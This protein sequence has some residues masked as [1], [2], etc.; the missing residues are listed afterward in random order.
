[1]AKELYLSVDIISLSQRE[2][3]F[4]NQARRSSAELKSNL[5]DGILHPCKK[6]LNIVRTD[7]NCTVTVFGKKYPYLQPFVNLCNIIYSAVLATELSLMLFS[8]TTV[9]EGKK[10]TDAK[11]PRAITREKR[12]TE[13]RPRLS[14]ERK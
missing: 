5:E 7:K 13:W 11:A 9:P 8:F 10:S 2:Y 4:L 6:V 1:M 3:Y 12:K 14:D